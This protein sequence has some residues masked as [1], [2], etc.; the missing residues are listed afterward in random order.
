MFSSDVWNDSGVQQGCTFG[1]ALFCLAML[2]TIAALRSE[3]CDDPDTPESERCRFLHICDDAYIVG[4]PL[5]ALAMAARWEELIGLGDH[6]SADPGPSLAIK[7][8]KNH[9]F[10]TC[11][12]DGLAGF[13]P[14]TAQRPYALFG[15]HRVH[16]PSTGLKILGAFVGTPEWVE[17]QLMRETQ[18]LIGRFY[19]LE[20]IAHDLYLVQQL[21]P[22]CYLPRFT[23]CPR[24]HPPA[25]V[26]KAS[27]LFDAVTVAMAEKLYDI[28]ELDSERVSFPRRLGGAGLRNQTRTS[29][30]AFF[31]GCSSGMDSDAFHLDP[32]LCL[33]ASSLDSDP[34]DDEIPMLAALRQARATCIAYGAVDYFADHSVSDAVRLSAKK[35]AQ[36]RITAQIEQRAV[37]VYFPDVAPDCALLGRLQRKCR[38]SNVTGKHV[39]GKFMT[40]RAFLPGETNNAAVRF[41][42]QMHLDIPLTLETNLCG[43][44]PD[45]SPMLCPLCNVTMQRDHILSCAKCALSERFAKHEKVSKT[46]I[47]ILRSVGLFP[48]AG[49]GG[50]GPRLRDP[51]AF[52]RGSGERNRRTDLEIGGVMGPHG[53]VHTDFTVVANSGGPMCRDPNDVLNTARL[54]ASDPDYFVV[55]KGDKLKMKKYVNIC[56]AAGFSFIPFA[57][58]TGGRTSPEGLRLIKLIYAEVEERVDSWY[59]YGVLLP[60]LYA[61]LALAQ[62]KHSVAIRRAFD[63]KLAAM[64]HGA[65][66]SRGCFA[67]DDPMP[68]PPPPSAA[69]AR[70]DFVDSV[71]S[72]MDG[73]WGSNA[74]GSCT[75]DHERAAEY[76]TFLRTVHPEFFAG[77]A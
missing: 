58:S 8:G 36:K 71:D 5:R 18:S 27:E 29:H 1:S 30:G 23:H 60:R 10:S 55:Q 38:Y 17:E 63:V 14:P 26:R 25:L 61:A 64:R 31:A 13:S 62:Y 3:F 56:R 7:P 48:W 70:Y 6:S 39:G 11:P 75:Y 19:R 37:D 21:I 34:G 24:C 67:E 4:P 53:T 57:L 12:L 35:G 32:D 59:F 16:P 52:S 41:M 28:G 20:L 76:A 15:S 51:R 69:N 73:R 49:A 42:L 2:K 33:L 74:D 54:G 72:N 68:P 46:L 50:G 22:M 43:E 40:P 77:T 45:G 47:A 66:R 44:L 65:F 9:V